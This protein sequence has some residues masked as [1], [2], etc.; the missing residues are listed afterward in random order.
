[1]ADG[2]TRAA[3][4][5]HAPALLTCFHV[6]PVHRGRQ[7]RFFALQFGGRCAQSSSA[8]SDFL[9]QFLFSSYLPC[10]QGQ[11]RYLTLE[12]YAAVQ[13]NLDKLVV[14]PASLQEFLQ[15]AEGL[16]AFFSPM[17][18]T[19]LIPTR[20]GDRRR[21]AGGEG[22]RAVLLYRNMLSASPPPTPLRERLVVD[23]ERSAWLHGMERSMMYQRV[24][25]GELR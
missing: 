3:Q 19:G 20:V 21:R 4:P 23:E 2:H 8:D 15:R 11:P 18:S 16:D 7:G 13:R 12:G 22:Q 24:V 1:M 10:A 25:A 14:M 5:D 17:S 6:R 9:S